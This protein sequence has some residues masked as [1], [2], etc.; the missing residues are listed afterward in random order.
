MSDKLLTTYEVCRRLGICATVLQRL[1]RER[2]IAF[3]K[4]GHRSIRF[5]EEAVQEFLRRKEKAAQFAEVSQ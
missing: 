5:R 3:I 4:F 1:R 2:K